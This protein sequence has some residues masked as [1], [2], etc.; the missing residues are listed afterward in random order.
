MTAL[1]LK[2]AAA[3]KIVQRVLGTFIGGTLGYLIMLRQHV[4]T[5]GAK[6]LALVCA[7]TFVVAQG[8]RSM[9]QYTVFLTVL[10]MTS[11]TICQYPQCCT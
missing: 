4:H 5:R 10:T 7:C 6:V 2:E 1:R 11:L 3:W 8:L 9:L